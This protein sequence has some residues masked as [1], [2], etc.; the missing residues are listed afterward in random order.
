MGTIEGNFCDQYEFPL[1][2]PIL[3][4]EQALET[5]FEGKMCQCTCSRKEGHTW[6]CLARFHLK[7]VWPSPE[8]IYSFVR[9]HCQKLI[10]RPNFNYEMK[11]IMIQYQPIEWVHMLTPLL[12]YYEDEKF[13]LNASI[14]KRVKNNILPLSGK[15]RRAP[16]TILTYDELLYYSLVNYGVT[17]KDGSNVGYIKF[18][19]M[20]AQFIR[21]IYYLCKSNGLHEDMFF[22]IFESTYNIKL[23]SNELHH[24][25]AIS[26][27]V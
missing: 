3:K 12:M 18:G 25:I 6:I 7:C 1:F 24:L 11:R 23:K 9:R 4:G 13:L 14:Q 19:R 22:M 26:T 15:L 2:L 5:L 27:L 20:S 8:S 16:S 17:I 10:S 21:V